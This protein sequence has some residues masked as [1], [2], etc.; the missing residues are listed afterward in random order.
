MFAKITFIPKFCGMFT[1]ITLI[2]TFY[3]ML[4]KITFISTCCNVLLSGLRAQHNYQKST[5]S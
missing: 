4:A 5:F 3:S 1:K 2:P